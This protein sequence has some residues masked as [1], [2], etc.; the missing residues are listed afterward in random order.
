MS[1]SSSSHT[2][3]NASES[4]HIASLSKQPT[5][6]SEEDP[7][8]HEV[9]SGRFASIHSP[10]PTLAS[11]LSP[12]TRRG[13]RQDISRYPRM[14]TGVPVSH[15]SGMTLEEL[16]KMQY[17]CAEITRA[18]YTADEAIV[19]GKRTWYLGLSAVILVLALVLMVALMLWNP[20]GNPANNNQGCSYKTFMSCN[21]KEFYDNEGTVGLLSWIEG[22]ESKLH[23]SKCSNDSKVEYI[24]CLVQVPHMVTLED[25]RINR[26]IWGLAPEIRTMVT[27]ANPS[28]IQSTVVLANRLTNCAIRYEVLKKDNVGNK[29]REENQSRNRGRGNPNE[30]QRF[31]RNYGMAAQGANKYI[32]EPEV[33]LKPNLKPSIPYP[34]RLNNQKLQ[35]KTNNQM[36]KFL[37]IFQ[38][39]HLDNSLMDALLHMPNFASTFK[40][41]LS[42]KEKLFELA[43]TPLNDNCSAV[44]LKKLPEN[45]GDLIK[46]LIPCDFPKLDEC[47]ALADLGASINLMSLSVWKKL[48]LPELTPT[49]D[50]DVDP[51]VP[52]ILRRPF[53]RTKQA[54]I[55]VHG[56]ELT[57][58]VNDEAITIKFGHTSR[59]SRNYYDESVNQI[60]VIDVACAEYAQEVLGFSDSST[61]GNATPSDPIIASSSPSFTP[62]EGGYFILEEIETFLHT[63]NN[64]SNLD[65]YYYDTE[66]DILYLEKLLN[67]DPSPNLPPMK[68]EDLKQVD[69]TMTKSSIEE[70]SELE[71]KDLLLI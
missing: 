1:R 2:A 71:L 47:L 64:P 10:T 44:L 54:L 67:E 59:Y 7:L 65:D 28:T 43:S 52:L 30:R 34:S 17:L 24:A 32:P 23:I 29:K 58:R 27:S 38:R 70:P 14:A 55:D 62:F 51:R 22:M 37:Q 11:V 40:S 45:L 9:S 42:N 57:L 3:H 16:S 18:I 31:A 25:K 20:G 33:V 4:G 69:V 12:P 35:E 21:P 48:S 5:M 6:D 8:E 68:N 13:P 15:E 50:Y 36:M 26:Y 56:E 41:L 66:G 49:L 60:N 61:S 39:L 46:F 53:L 63:P 19:I